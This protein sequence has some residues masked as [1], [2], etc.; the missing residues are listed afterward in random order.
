ME[1]FEKLLESYT[2]HK[3]LVTKDHERRNKPPMRIGLQ[4][5]FIF[6][7]GY[8]NEQSKKDCS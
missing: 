6:T 3:I 2:S 5:Q 4:F 7:D 8:L 1:E